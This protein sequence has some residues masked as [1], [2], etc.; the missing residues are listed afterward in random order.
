ME[1]C[2]RCKK[3]FESVWRVDDEIWKRV[4]GDGDTGNLCANCFDQIA[5]ERGI[6]L[7]W[8]C[9]EKE[10]PIKKIKE[11]FKK[12]YKMTKIKGVKHE[13]I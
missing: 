2:K 13:F 5:R 1:K 10:Y 9:T 4:Q 12:K 6:E 7:F 3:D 11:N 8:E